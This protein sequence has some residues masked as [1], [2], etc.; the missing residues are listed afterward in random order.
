MTKITPTTDYIF[1]IAQAAGVDR[2]TARK[3]LLAAQT[4]SNDLLSADDQCISDALGDA[5]D[6]GEGRPSGAMLR[7]A[8]LAHGM[9][10]MDLQPPSEHVAADG[11]IRKSHYGLDRQPLDDIK[12]QGWA[13]AFYAGNILKYLRRTKAPV[14]SLQSAQRYYG[15][16]M[17]MAEHDVAKTH[18]GAWGVLV[19]LN[20]LLT[21]EETDKLEGINNG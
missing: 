10:V 5:I 13:P 7:A 12:E 16:L 4:D 8:L 20:E 21:P 2:D 17:E 3:V 6:D 11:T 1:N 18:D 15:W 9:Q 14:H 19:S